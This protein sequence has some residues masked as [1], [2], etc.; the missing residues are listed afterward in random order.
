MHLHVCGLDFSQPENW[1]LREN[2]PKEQPFWENLAEAAW[3]FMIQIH[4]PHTR[5][6]EVFIYPPRFKVLGC[7]HHFSMGEVSENWRRHVL[8]LSYWFELWFLYTFSTRS[9]SY[10]RIKVV[11]Y[12]VLS[13]RDLRQALILN[14]KPVNTFAF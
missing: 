9:V 2:L 10:L 12:L 1:L 8:K 4:F 14:I 6:A 3:L 13:S 7:R 5:M 11:S